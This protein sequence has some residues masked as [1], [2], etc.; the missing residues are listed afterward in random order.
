MV[1]DDEMTGETSSRSVSV[2]PWPERKYDQWE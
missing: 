2:S 1:R